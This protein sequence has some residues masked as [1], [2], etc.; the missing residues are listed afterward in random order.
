MEGWVDLGNWL[1]AE[2]VSRT[3]II[4]LTSARLGD[5]LQVQR[6]KHHTAKAAN[7]ERKSRDHYF[8]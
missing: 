8:A 2:M 7:R 6:H 5:E 1:H 3:Q 4:H